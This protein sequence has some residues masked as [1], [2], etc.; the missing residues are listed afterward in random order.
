[1]SLGTE[2]KDRSDEQRAVVYTLRAPMYLDFSCFSW[3][4]WAPP[5]FPSPRCC[6]RCASYCPL[7][8]GSGRSAVADGSRVCCRQLTSAFELCS[9]GMVL[10]YTYR[11]EVQ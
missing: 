11:H 10:P 9:D 4:M 3:L 7:R 8:C 2:S 5:L 1:M 6:P